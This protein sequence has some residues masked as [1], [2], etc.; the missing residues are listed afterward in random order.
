MA[1]DYSSMESTKVNLLNLIGIDTIIRLTWCIFP[2]LKFVNALMK[3]AHAKN[4]FVCDYIVVV[5][6][7]QANLYKMYGNSNTS[8]W[9]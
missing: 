2:M 7:Y 6:F 8:F 9:V 5:K 1:I 3:F 4:G